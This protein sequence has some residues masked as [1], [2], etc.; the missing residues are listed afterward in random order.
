MVRPADTLPPKTE[1]LPPAA[2]GQQASSPSMHYPLTSANMRVNLNKVLRQLHCYDLTQQ[3]DYSE[4]TSRLYL[5]G[6]RFH[7]P[8]AKVEGRDAIVAFWD[9]FLLGEPGTQW[10]EG[11]VLLSK[12]P[13]VGGLSM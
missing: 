7:Y 11:L 8:L 3:Q 1:L 2:A 9:F 13:S 6:A 12:M 10:I 4:L 5:P